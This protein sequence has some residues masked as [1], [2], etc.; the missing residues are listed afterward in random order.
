MITLNIIL[1]LVFLIGAVV[2]GFHTGVEWNWWDGPADCSGG[3]G[4]S[5][6]SSMGEIDF[7]RKF[8]TVSCSDAAWR[9]FGISMAGY[10]TLISVALAAMSAF[11]S[12]RAFDNA[13]RPSDA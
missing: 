8:S 1:C 5:L 7:D 3:V 9:M 10:N 4:G 11:Q 2:A 6:P 12:V 13:S